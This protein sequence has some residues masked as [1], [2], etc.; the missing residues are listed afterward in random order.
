MVLEVD[1]P[2][3]NLLGLRA[4]LV[5]VCVNTRACSL[6]GKQD[7]ALFITALKDDIVRVLLTSTPCET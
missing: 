6:Y 2:L 7:Q 4:V 1:G 3:V 5:D